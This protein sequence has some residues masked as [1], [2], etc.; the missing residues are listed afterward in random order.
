MLAFLEK[1]IHQKDEERPNSDLLC[2][3]F[4]LSQLN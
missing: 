1:I 4:A 2:R 3:D